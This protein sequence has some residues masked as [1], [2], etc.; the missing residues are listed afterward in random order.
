MAMESFPWLKD[1]IWE[2]TSEKGIEVKLRTTWKSE[3]DITENIIDVIRVCNSYL[4]LNAM[5][6]ILSIPKLLPDPFF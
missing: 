3:F 4:V 2:D 5:S 1:P 6:E